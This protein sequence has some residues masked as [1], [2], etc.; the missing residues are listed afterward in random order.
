[1]VGKLTDSRNASA[2]MLP[3]IMGVNPYQTRN[4]ALS[5]C[6]NAR[7]GIAPEFTGNE[8]TEWG[9]LLEPTILS[10]AARRLGLTRWYEPK[11][12]FVHPN[13]PLAA[14]L[15]GIGEGEGV[16]IKHDPDNGIYVM[17]YDEITIEHEI[18]MEAKNARCEA[19]ATPSAYRGPVQ[20]QGQMM[21]STIHFG[22]V[23]VL[24]RGSEL[25]I[26]VYRTNPKMMTQISE[27][28][29]D[30]ARRLDER[31][32]YPA[33]SSDDCNTIWPVADEEAPTIDLPEMID[34]VSVVELVEAHVAANAA[35]KACD[36]TKGDVEQVLK[37]LLGNH[38]KGRVGN[39]VVAWP[40]RHYKAQPEKITPAKEARSVRQSTLTI[41]EVS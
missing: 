36:G 1:M 15:D 13:I 37:E 25:R 8:L 20:I 16:T 18:V 17:G 11:Q 23:C 38:E 40:M 2:S 26:F 39:Y 22:A 7:D 41:K 34:D 21:C 30:F 35:K 10:E 3:A 33:E 31:D 5:Y 6:L 28:C 9:N 32:F 27:A 19:E 12:A 24:Y 14:S 29:V 4:D